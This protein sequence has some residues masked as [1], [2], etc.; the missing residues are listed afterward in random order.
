MKFRPEQ[1]RS[2]PGLRRGLGD[3]LRPLRFGAEPFT[4][5]F[6]ENKARMSMKT[7][8]RLGNQ[9]PLT[10]SYQGGDSRAPSQTRRGQGAVEL[11]GV[12][13]TLPCMYAP[14]SAD[15]ESNVGATHGTIIFRAVIHARPLTGAQKP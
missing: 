14:C 6:S 1:C 15:L 8:D 13:H 5:G 3:V 10:P 2:L 12:A 4:Y 9:P 7:K 11:S